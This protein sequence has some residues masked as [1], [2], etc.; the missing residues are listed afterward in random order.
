MH[1]RLLSIDTL[2]GLTEYESVNDFIGFLKEEKSYGAVY[3]KYD[4]ISHRAQAEEVIDE[5]LFED[6]GK[7]Y[8][9]ANK[10][11]RKCREIPFL[12]YEYSILKHGI[13][14]VM[15]GRDEEHDYA[16]GFF[17]DHV[18]FDV[19]EMQ[20]VG[21]M[22]ELLTLLAGTEFEGPVRRINDSPEPTYSDYA[23][24]L[25][26]QFFELAWKKKD[27]IDSKVTRGI[28]EELIGTEID[29]QNIMWIYRHKKF[30]D[31]TNADIYDSIIPV[32]YRLKKDELRRMAEAETVDQ[33]T[34]ILA[35][36]AYVTAKD[37]VVTLD[38]E[39]SYRKVMDNVFRKACQKH[40]MS[41]APVYRYLHDKEHEID[42]LTTIMEGVRYRIPPREIADSLD[43]HL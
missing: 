42:A 32:R 9:F 40:P 22:S 34:E 30:Y 43:Y 27:Q 39:V 38:D 5:S 19:L 1:G 17:S 37:P 11:Q 6:F 33:L 31:S 21:S 7:L 25:D 3:Q 20:H 8:S 14:K 13:W 41:I 12:K 24:T 23:T 28:V 10:E 4:S 35:K 2:Y 36:T 29:W 16:R 18:S 15:N 26:K